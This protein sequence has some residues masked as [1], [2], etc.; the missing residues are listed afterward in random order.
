MGLNSSL[1]YLM[2]LPILIIAAITDFRSRIIPNW[3]TLPAIVGGLAYHTAV[4]GLSGFI[5]GLEGVLLGFAL[6]IS[7]FLAGGM[8][9]GDVK[10]LGAVGSLLGPKGVFLV[11]LY[12]AIAGGIIA[13]ALLWWRG[14]L[15][16]TI[17]RYMT[18]LKTFLITR[19]IF[20]MP[21]EEKQDLPALCYGVVIG[22]GTIFYIL[23]DITYRHSF[24]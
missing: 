10:L 12:T 20:Y 14:C 21:P 17:K 1:M 8:G 13:L 24:F 5:F 3:L 22:L 11:F 15:T 6:L 7:F 4:N 19:R 18:I 2:L 9:A 23:K 16:V